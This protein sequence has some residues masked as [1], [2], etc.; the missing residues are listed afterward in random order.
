CSLC[1]RACAARPPAR[2]PSLGE[3][4]AQG[5]SNLQ[6]PWLGISAFAVLAIMLSLLVFIGEAARDAFDPRK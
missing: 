6:A 1:I 2:A 3:L 5:K 4:V